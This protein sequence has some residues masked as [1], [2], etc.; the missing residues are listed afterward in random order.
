MHS[1]SKWNAS[2][3][4]ANRAHVT[5]TASRAFVDTQGTTC[6]DRTRPAERLLLRVFRERRSRQL[7][8][9]DIPDVSHGERDRRNVSM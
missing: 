1:S 9:G 8:W 5:A 7:D 6:A 2:S 3:V 4:E